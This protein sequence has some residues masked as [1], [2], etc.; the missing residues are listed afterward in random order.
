MRNAEVLKGVKEERNIL[1]T[2]KRKKDNWICLTLRRNFH[3]KHAFRENIEERIEGAKRRGRRRKELL[4]H[5]KKKGE[6]EIE[7]EALD[8]T[9][10]RTGFGRGYGPVVRQITK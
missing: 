5:L 8:Y 7:E 9:L 10:W 4:D 2:V 6:V 3:L 1:Q